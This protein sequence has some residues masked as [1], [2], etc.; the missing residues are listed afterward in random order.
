[1]Q[2][3]FPTVAG[4]VE[5]T[6]IYDELDFPAGRDGRPWT[7]VNMVS[8][9]DGKTT[10]DLNRV[11]EPIGSV[12]DRTLMKRLRV[13]FDAVIRGAGTVRT[14]SFYPGVPAELE[15]RRIALGLA[16]QPLAVVVTGTGNLPLEAP[17]F[18]KAPRRPLVVTAATV[19]RERLSAIEA[20][21]DVAVL[22]ASPLDLQAVWRLLFEA[23]GVRRLLSEGGPRFNH[24]CLKEGLVDEIFWTVAPRIA[25]SS[26]DLTMVSGPALL[27][28]MPRLEL[29]SAYC[30]ENELFLRWRL[31]EPE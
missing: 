14:D 10:L 30:H 15:H 27:Q 31:V 7:A 5:P 12:L 6:A 23:Y 2:R 9:I 17:F 1:M 19:P 4:H 13:H 25:G 3:L 18:Q 11:R 20:V 24:G 22:D 16:R 21:A 29:V 26:H 8:T 28:P